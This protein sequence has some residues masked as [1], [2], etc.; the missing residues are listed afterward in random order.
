MTASTQA[1]PSCCR[2]L[3]VHPANPDECETKKYYVKVEVASSSTNEFSQALKFYDEKKNAL[4]DAQ[5]KDT[6]PV[7]KFNLVCFDDSLTK[8]NQFADIWLFSHDG[9]G[10]DFAPRVHLED[11]N[12][13]S[14]YHEENK[15]FSNR[16]EDLL[17]AEQVKMTVE[18]L[19]DP[20]GNR[21]LRAL[22]VQ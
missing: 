18:V 3:C 22:T 6:I 14:N 17:N 9:K 21:M 12:E 16:V 7:Y 20:K 8:K 13:F 19:A 4:V 15:Y 1:W 2:C 10:A 11:L 5:R